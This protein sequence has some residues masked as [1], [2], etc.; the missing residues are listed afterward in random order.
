M[1]T[2]GFYPS[3]SAST[4]TIAPSSAAVSI[5]FRGRY[6]CSERAMCGANRPIKLNGPITMVQSVVIAAT[7]SRSI[8]RTCVA[9][10]PM[11]M[12]VTS[13]SSIIAIQRC[14][15]KAAMA[16]KPTPNA[17]SKISELAT[18]YVEPESQVS[19]EVA[20]SC[21]ELIAIRSSASS[22]ALSAIPVNRVWLGAKLCFRPINHSKQGDRQSANSTQQHLLLALDS[23]AQHTA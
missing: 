22:P 10:I 8:K 20:L 7:S 12:A 15:N 9:L 2:K 1:G 16:T 18:K 11:L 4:I 21:P 3:Q 17:S 5:C 19:R 14:N 13:P 6:W 23:N